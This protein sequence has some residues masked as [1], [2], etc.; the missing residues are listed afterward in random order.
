MFKRNKLKTYKAISDF[1]E[2]TL[3]P[4]LTFDELF[5][6]SEKGQI[7][8]PIDRQISEYILSAELDWFITIHNL[9]D[10]LIIL[11]REINGVTTR[12]NLNELL[13]KYNSDIDRF[14]WEAESLNSLLKIFDLTEGND[15]RQIFF[16]FSLRMQK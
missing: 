7:S 9:N 8:D 15:L 4:N 6:L 2:A 11:E 16:E 3:I 10:F 13:E 12:E 5:D 14:T 1:I